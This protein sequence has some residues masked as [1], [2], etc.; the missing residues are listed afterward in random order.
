MSHELYGA[1]VGTLCKALVTH[2]MTLANYLTSV[3]LSFILQ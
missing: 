1:I 3:S 2:S